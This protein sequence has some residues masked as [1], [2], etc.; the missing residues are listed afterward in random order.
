[1]RILLR[2]AAAGLAVLVAVAAAPALAQDQAQLKGR[3]ELLLEDLRKSGAKIEYGALEA[4]AGPEGLVIRDLVIT[5]PD[6]TAIKIGA[7]EIKAYD[8][9]NP[10]AA[11]YVD[12]SLR[13]LVIPLKE[14]EESTAELREMGYK[15]LRLAADIAYKYDEASKTLDISKIALDVADLGTLRFAL[16][17]GGLTPADLTALSKLGGGQPPAGQPPAGQPPAGQ[18]PAAADPMAILERMTIVSGTLAFR[19]K[20][21]VRRAIARQAKSSGKSEAD[22]KSEILAM[23]AEQRKAAQDDLTREAID[24]AIKFVMQPGEF[25][26]ALKPP[27][28]ANVMAVFG[29]LMAGP[30]ALKGA[31]GITF[32]VRP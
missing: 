24:A 22:G 16:A 8:W 15:E 10:R 26:V 7:I 17:I 25:E 28:P 32:N 6:G 18:P 27:Q 2:R 1:M 19:D 4:G 13:D 12:A 31:L 20:S 11:R 3:A 30:A 21:L 23:L 9:A 5:D 29:M 14:D